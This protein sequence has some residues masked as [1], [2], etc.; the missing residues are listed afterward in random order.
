MKLHKVTQTVTLAAFLGLLLLATYP[1]PDGLAADFFLRLDPLICL[2]TLIASRGF[3][4]S[5][6]PGLL[7]LA[8][9]VFLGRFFCGHICPMGTTLDIL[10]S[11]LVSRKKPSVKNNSYESTQRYR[12]WKYLGLIAILASAFTGVSLVYWG[13]PLSL[14]TRFYGLVVYPVLLLTADWILQITGPLLAS[15]PFSSL[16][17]LQ[18]PERVF[19]T[20][21]FVF[22][23][24]LGITIL[25]YAQPRFWC[26]N[27]CPA[28]ALMGLFS[29]SPVVR[30]RVN[31]DCT[32]CGLCVRNCPTAAISE[33]PARTAHAECIVCLRCMEVCPESAISFSARSL[34]K[35]TEKINPDLTRRNMVLALGSGLVTAGVLRTG[36]HQPSP[37]SR[38]RALVNPELIRPPGALPE[39]EFLARC[40]RC[41]ECMKACPTNTLQPVWLQAGLE[42]IFTPVMLPRLAACSIN[43]NTC[44]KVCPTGAIRN[45]PLA[46]KKHAKV[47][48][49]W[50][51]RQNC[52]V[53]EQ[54]KKCLVCDEVCP[55]NAVSFR[56][57][58]DRV[59]GV[60][61]ITENKC[62]GCGWCESKCPVEGASA[63]RV[64]IIGE[65]RLASGS[66][67]EKAREY[68]AIF[69]ERDLGPERLAPGTF[70][71]ATPSP[72]G[73]AAPAAPKSQE[74][75][76]PP[77]FTI[78]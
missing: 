41:G 68:G 67:I 73:G 53:W 22:L 36:V 44:G 33:E 5:L 38:E 60:P 18:I 8:A 30:R 42:G 76:L 39:P 7:I 49:A 56:P 70:D 13:S 20:G 46:E 75:Q 40:I 72:E 61:F 31:E 43:C 74:E 78:K 37:R 63:I 57:V 35:P 19:A 23:L 77:G 52:L 26:R 71:S 34:H 28:G 45:L 6:L 32:K 66:Y 25:G 2:G 58:P 17:Y 54:D 24:F 65:I 29:R 16:N 59:N 1:F 12:K 14:V 15:T 9:A 51:N 21:A 55:Y 48:T 62:T 3:L 69:K 11:A 10:Q 47:G 27:L 64:N 4:V 50:I